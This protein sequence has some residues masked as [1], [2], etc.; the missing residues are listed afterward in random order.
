[1]TQTLAIFLDAYRDLNSRKL[2]WLAVAISALVV[3]I[4][5]PGNFH[6]MDDLK[7]L[8]GLNIEC[9]VAAED[10]IAKTRQRFFGAQ[11]QM[12]LLDDMNEISGLKCG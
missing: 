9:V 3:A 7:F 1:M 2:F 6:A 11:D 12:A 4:V 10:D 5:D 8:T